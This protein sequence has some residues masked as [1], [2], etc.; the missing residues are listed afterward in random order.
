MS[1][2]GHEDKENV[3]QSTTAGAVNKR[4]MI[5]DYILGIE[6]MINLIR[7]NLGRGYFRQGQIGNSSDNVRE[8]GDKDFGEGAHC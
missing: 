8:G 2:V 4:R 1:V 6:G 3:G 7:S 5:G